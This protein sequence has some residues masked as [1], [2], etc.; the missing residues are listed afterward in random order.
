M[1]GDTLGMYMTTS[2]P[3]KPYQPSAGDVNALT[4]ALSGAL[5]GVRSCTFDLS[6]FQIND[7][8]L[9]E[10]IVSVVDSSGMHDVPLDKDSKDGWYMTNI[11]PST[12]PNGV[13]THT[14]TQLQLFGSWCEKLRAPTT[15]DIKFNFPC[16]LIITIN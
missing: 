6:T 3:T 1:R 8:K 16:D 7:D 15:T 9:S 14:A 2:G 5:S 4:T 13:V 12:G 10:A 11:T